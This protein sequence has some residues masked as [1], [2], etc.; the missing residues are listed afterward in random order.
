MHQILAI[1]VS[2]VDPIGIWRTELIKQMIPTL[3]LAKTI[4][5]THA[6]EGRHVIDGTV[7]IRCPRISPFF[8]VPH[9]LIGFKGSELFSFCSRV[10]FAL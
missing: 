3:P 10:G 5:I 4:R 1:A 6:V 9:R 7:R 8:I 2:P